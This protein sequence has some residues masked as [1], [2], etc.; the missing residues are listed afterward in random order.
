[1]AWE[2]HN[3]LITSGPKAPDSDRPE[4]ETSLGRG[5]RRLFSL[6][7]DCLQGDASGYD[8]WNDSPADSP[9]DADRRDV[10]SGQSSTEG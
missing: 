2:R 3:F 7:E 4:S 9:G 5:S 1:M 6:I 10:D 8:S